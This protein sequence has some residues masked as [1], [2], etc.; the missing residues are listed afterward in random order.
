MSP[1]LRWGIFAI[2]AFAALWFVYNANKDVTDRQ[3]PASPAAT[4]AVTAQLPPLSAVCQV[5]LTIAQNARI[6]RANGDPLDRLLR[7]Q[8][9]SFEEDPARRERL[10]TIAR[11]WFEME[12]E[13][14]PTML[15]SAVT[16]ECEQ[17]VQAQAA[18]AAQAPAPAPAPVTPP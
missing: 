1:F 13:V 10:S 17:G 11:H 7:T 9:I 8:E 6:A 2:V 5:E 3:A 12:G 15:R 16:S 4:S 14:D 18:A